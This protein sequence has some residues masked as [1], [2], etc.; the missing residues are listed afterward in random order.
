MKKFLKFLN[1]RSMA[2]IYLNFLAVECTKY[3]EKNEDFKVIF[4]EKRNKVCLVK[5]NWKNE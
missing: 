5:K 3:D 1:L 2:D 4:I